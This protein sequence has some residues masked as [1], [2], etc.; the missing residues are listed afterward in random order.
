[1]ANQIEQID[2]VLA[3]SDR[4]KLMPLEF[5][6]KTSGKLFVN[7][8]K[9]LDW[10]TVPKKKENDAKLFPRNMQAETKKNET[11]DDINLSKNT[12]IPIQ[13]NLNLNAGASFSQNATGNEI[14]FGA[15]VPV[16]IGNKVQINPSLNFNASSRE[17]QVADGVILNQKGLGIGAVVEGQVILNDEG[18]NKL[19]ARF[20]QN[21]N[22]NF[23]KFKTP[24]NTIETE[25]GGSFTKWSGGINL[26]KLG[27]N[28]GD[29]NITY[30]LGDN[31]KFYVDP[32]QVGVQFSIPLGGSKER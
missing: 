30:T 8:D 20:N 31:G 2:R 23:N 4:S 26:G 21:K 19:W 6:P 11:G 25:D 32:N 24:S 18:S 14:G 22:K 10:I 12:F 1:M 9:S 28:I 27:I 16:T 3:K 7:E 5:E 13:D 17:Q 15:N 29:K